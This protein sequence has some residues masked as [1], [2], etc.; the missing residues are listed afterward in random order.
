MTK[1]EF[2]CVNMPWKGLQPQYLCGIV[3]IY[4]SQ[5]PWHKNFNLC[6]FLCQS[7][8]KICPIL[9]KNEKTAKIRKTPQTS[10]YGH[11]KGFENI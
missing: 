8:E 2:F 4:A 5:K 7:P 9:R 3:K 10:I 1:Q 11:L 6:Q